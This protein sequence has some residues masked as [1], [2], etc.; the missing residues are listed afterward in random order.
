MGFLVRKEA[1]LLVIPFFVCL[2]FYTIKGKAYKQILIMISI[3]IIVNTINSIYY[4]EETLKNA[5]DRQSYASAILDYEQLDS[6]E[7]KII[8]YPQENGLISL[9][10]TLK[11]TYNDYKN[12][13]NDFLHYTMSEYNKI[14]MH[15]RIEKIKVKMVNALHSVLSHYLIFI[16]L[17]LFVIYIFFKMSLPKNIL[18][19][20]I[21]MLVMDCYFYINGRAVDRVIIIPMIM[22]I[23][24]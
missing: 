3:L 10:Y 15:N 13:S 1:A 2:Y 11:W 14:R 21:L 16:C 19:I 9:E 22:T 12:I 17:L 7:K 18:I 20:G 6:E 8:D 5:K 23:I 24:I 4:S